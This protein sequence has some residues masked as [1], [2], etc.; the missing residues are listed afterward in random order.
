MVVDRVGDLVADLI[1][2]DKKDLPVIVSLARSFGVD[3]RCRFHGCLIEEAYLKSK[4]FDLITSMSIIEHITDDK[5]AIQKMWDLLK[6]GDVLLIS[7]P[8]EAK[9]SEDLYKSK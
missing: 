2:A 6:P 3:D 9:T 7:I 4:S 8:C 5:G 1:N